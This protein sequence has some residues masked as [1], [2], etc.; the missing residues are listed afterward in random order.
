MKK[1]SKEDPT[2]STGTSFKIE[3]QILKKEIDSGKFDIEEL[4]ALMAALLLLTKN[5]IDGGTLEIKIDP[6]T[7]TEAATVY[8][9]SD[10]KPVFTT[11][12][13]F[14]MNCLK[15]PRR[16]LEMLETELEKRRADENLIEDIQKSLAQPNEEFK[17]S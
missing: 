14:E 7:K 4:R 11:E 16:S 17:E 9:N 15:D 1:V 3:V 12:D 10:H 5:N 8:Q 2:N 13:L 6:V